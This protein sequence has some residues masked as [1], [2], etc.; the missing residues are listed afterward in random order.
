M[1][2]QQPFPLHI[3]LLGGFGLSYGERT[4]QPEQ[5][6]LRKAR[7]LIKILALAP[8]H[9]RHRDQLVEYLWP[10]TDPK[11]AANNLYQA[12]FAARKVL[13]TVLD[14]HEV[15]QFNE[16][17]LCLCPD[18]PLR[19]DIEV[20]EGATAK[21]RSSQ[22]PAAFHA[23]LD[24]YTGDLLPED[25]YEEWAANR[26]EV[27]RQDH[28]YLLLALAGMQEQTKDY[29]ACISTFQ[30]AL[31]ANPV[32]EEAHAG[33]MRLFAL[34]G[35]RSA[36]L[37]QYETCR[38]AL[39]IELGV[40]PS[41]HTTILY[42]QISAGT[43]AA[44]PLTTAHAQPAPSRQTK[45]PTYLI[46]FVGRNS[47]LT[48][49]RERLSDPSCRLLT[50]TGPGG[51][52]KTRLAVE[53]VSTLAVDFPDGIYFVPLAGVQSPAAIVPAIAQALGFTFF[54]ERNPRLQL[55][56]YLRVKTIL[57]VLDNFEHLLVPS[58]LQGE[59][60][61]GIVTQILEAA[62]GVKVVVT[63]RIKLDLLY[64]TLL[65]IH[66]MRTPKDG[67][68]NFTNVLEYSA[69]RLFLE[70][71]RRVFPDFEPSTTDLDHIFDICN[72]V[73]GM[74][75]AIL[76]AA[77]WVEILTPGEIAAEVH[78]GL[79]FLESC[80]Q[81]L[82][83]RQR[84]LRAVFNHSW[85]L[86]DDQAQSLF[87]GLSIF[88]GG[89]STEAAKL[90]CGA[91]LPNLAGM[92]GK[93]LVQRSPEGRFEI[94]ELLRQFA[95]EKLAAQP[96]MEQ[97]IRDRHSRYFSDFL[98][99]R[100]HRLIVKNERAAIQETSLEIDNLRLA[101]DWSVEH[102]LVDVIDRCHF[103][104]A[105]FLI[106]QG[107]VIEGR[108]I[109][110]RAALRL[111]EIISTVDDEIEMRTLRL[112][113]AR[114]DQQQAWCC[115][116]LGQ[117]KHE[118]ELYLSSLTTFQELGDRRGEAWILK[119]IG[120]FR[121]FPIDDPEK[122]FLKSIRIYEELD[123]PFGKANS[124]MKLANRMAINRVD[125]AHTKK[126]FLECL[127][128]FRSLDSLNNIGRALSSLGNMHTWEGHYQEAERYYHEA[129]EVYRQTDSKVY[130]AGCIISLSSTL[131]LPG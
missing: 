7:N 35:Q 6:R 102:K 22:N 45:L 33:L 62:P 122:G 63:T 121:D 81:D 52:G 55:L 124:Q 17:F 127:A 54:D 76:L 120:D 115:L 8:S 51:C 30:Q 26:R 98:A 73:E 96:G 18:L 31:D 78:K 99:E 19:V 42:Q 32:C 59:E 113:I 111:R 14:A 126:L 61:A 67:V 10:D 95:E 3:H 131:L 79:D 123:D 86:L 71:A 11:T 91:D 107:M 93:S 109:F 25:L 23:A 94:H 101:W 34:S 39:E 75:L 87:A 65:P 44:Q 100:E 119:E 82:P 108:E 21:A 15:L 2:L 68:E 117:T 116:Y 129:M 66:G 130:Y 58:S 72:L 97:E 16:E 50:L 41:P 105:R 77:G 83:E 47:L 9:R 49:V 36:A 69:V 64:E 92:V 53:S 12:L 43:L 89:F 80:W 114:L 128:I 37:S 48:A 1:T 85:Q 103:A 5:F 28:L 40:E 4:V 74:P 60:G 20:F 110:E 56:D 84:S 24:L 29:P 106:F 118:R 112:V 104:F 27:L 38:Q 70:G 46:P 125:F 13:A 88:R 57:L 90:I